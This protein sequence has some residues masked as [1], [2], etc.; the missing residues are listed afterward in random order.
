M[1][2]FHLLLEGI[3]VTEQLKFEEASVGCLAQPA[4]LCR[5]LTSELDRV[6]QGRV[7][8]SSELL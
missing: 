3:R 7:Q 6:A 1:V 2:S 8:L 4:A 5:E